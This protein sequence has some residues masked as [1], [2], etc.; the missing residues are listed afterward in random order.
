MATKVATIRWVLKKMEETKEQLEIQLELADYVARRLKQ[1]P[2]PTIEEITEALQEI[3]LHLPNLRSMAKGNF[4]GATLLR[5]ESMQVDPDYRRRDREF[6][7]E[8][9]P[10]PPEDE[11]K[12]RQ[13]ERF[14]KRPKIGD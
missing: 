12:K 8:I 2:T 1:D 9:N 4:D 11:I 5:G 3:N 13:A 6:N 10:K 14:A 7:A